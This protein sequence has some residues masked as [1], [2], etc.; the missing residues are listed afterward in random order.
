MTKRKAK[1]KAKVGNHTQTQNKQL[2]I[3]STMR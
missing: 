1:T 3:K 2:K